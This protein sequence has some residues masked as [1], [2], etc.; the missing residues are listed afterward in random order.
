MSNK[1]KGKVSCLTNLNIKCWCT[2]EGRPFVREKHFSCFSCFSQRETF[3]I[4]LMFFSE[5]NISH[6][7]HVFL[8]E[9]HVSYFSQREI[10]LMFFS[11]RN[12]SY[13]SC[14]S[15][16]KHFSCFCLTKDL[17]ARNVGHYL[18]IFRFRFVSDHCL[19]STLR[20]FH[21]LFLV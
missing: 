16:R 17:N 21:D 2:T 7:S 19:R 6:I 9:K 3:L 4:F 11:E 18:Y 1:S 20:L 10:F 13:F 8:R 5:R 14:F 12:N 15:Q